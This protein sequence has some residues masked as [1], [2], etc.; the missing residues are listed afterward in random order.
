MSDLI[1]KI[2]CKLQQDL[3]P[4][5]LRVI[6]ESYQHVGHASAGP[7]I[8]HI[9]VIIKADSLSG[10]SAIK[11]HQRIYTALNEWMPKPLHAVAIEIN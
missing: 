4:E 2:Q 3:Q 1:K 7:G 5:A 11:Q 8:Y 9:R 10:L 6:D